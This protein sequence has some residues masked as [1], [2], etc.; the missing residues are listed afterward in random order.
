MSEKK[1]TG[2]PLKPLTATLEQIE[3][4]ASLGLTIEEICR[5]LGVTKKTLYKRKK[6]YPELDEAIERGRIKA[7][8]QVVKALYTRATVHND[9]TAMIFWLKNRQPDRFRDRHELEHSGGVK[10]DGKLTLEVVDTDAEG[11]KKPAK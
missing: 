1:K 7:D 5:Y 3:M 4:L 11:N 2:R 6:E 10:F 8:A 9:T